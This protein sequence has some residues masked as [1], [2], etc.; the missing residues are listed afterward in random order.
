MVGAGSIR[1]REATT[2]DAALIASLN[3][4]VQA[5]HARLLPNRFKPPQ[6][7]TFTAV[8]AVELLGKA[9][10]TIYIALVDAEPAGYAYIELQRRPESPYAFAHDQVYLHHISVSPNYQRR[11]IGTAL[12]SAISAVAKARGSGRIALDVWTANEAA[13]AF[14]RAQGFLPYNERLAK[15]G[16]GLSQTAAKEP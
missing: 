5:L 14:F 16:W 13:R 12:M 8:D 9:E 2:A 4:H 15:G 11:G 6:R 10:N 1:V 3:E 7:G